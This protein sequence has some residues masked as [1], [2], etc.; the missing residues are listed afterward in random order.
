VSPADT[1]NGWANYETWA[2]ALWL[3]NDEGSYE[4]VRELARDAYDHATESTYATRG[5]CVAWSLAEHL[6][7]HHEECNP[8]ADAPATVFDDLLSAALSRVDWLEIAHNVVT[9]VLAE[10]VR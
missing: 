10:M 1:Y 9:E 7:E 6:K 4:W 3:D 5:E 8:L 2:V